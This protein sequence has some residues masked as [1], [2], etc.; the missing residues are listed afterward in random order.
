MVEIKFLGRGGQGAVTAANVVVQ[1][2]FKENKFGLAYPSFGA[3]RRGAILNAYARISDSY[4]NV[5][6]NIYEPDVV[7]VLDKKIIQMTN[8][9]EGLKPNGIVIINTDS[10]PDLSFDPN[11]N[12]KLF[13][14]DARRI[15][16]DLNLIVSGWPVVN[17]AML[18]AFSKATSLIKIDNIIQ[19]IKENWKGEIGEKNAKACLRAYD[20]TFEVLIKKRVFL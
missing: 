9:L 12:G 15:C 11:F 16:L 18:G 17:T 8:I 14:V 13:I 4:I 10:I 7:V 2:A 20:E 19:V 1:A 5:H 6:Q 3:E